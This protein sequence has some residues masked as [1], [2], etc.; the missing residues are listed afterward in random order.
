MVEI[1]H[2]TVPTNGVELALFEAGEPGAPVVVLSHGFP[3][4]AYSW[5]HQ[6]APLAEAG[7]HVLAPDQRGYGFSTAPKD[8]AAY[9]ADELA[10]DLLGLLDDV[11]A[12]DAVFVGH[13][14]GA[15][16]VWHMAKTVPE[17][18]R[19]VLAAS[20]P[21]T[22]W[23]APPTDLFKALSGDRFFYILYFQEVGPAERELEADV[24]ETMRTILWAAS[25]DA[26]RGMPAEQL[27]AE[28]TGFLDAMR[29]GAGP[30]PDELPSWLTPHDLD[31][32]TERFEAS[33]FFGPI[34]WYRNM[35]ADHER[36]KD[37]DSSVISMPTAFIGGTKDGVIAGRPEYVESMKLTLPNYR[38]ATMIEGAGHWTQQEAPEEFNRALLDFV[39]S[40]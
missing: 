13:D 15:L 40:L 20:V 22:P 1:R 26:Y 34:S 6:M 4:C 32:Y 33:G 27:P 16:L 14:W 18:M 11:G 24:R 36:T 8:V 37:I 38:G 25:G 19:G 10:A 28:G 12:Q 5:R 39:T 35:D 2:R 23:P 3:E 21:Y 17:R 30:V 9:H 7:F 31:V 29:H